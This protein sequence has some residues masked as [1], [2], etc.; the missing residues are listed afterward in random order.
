MSERQ[1]PILET[2]ERAAGQPEPRPFELEELSPGQEQARPREEEE[3]GG[4]RLLVY[5]GRQEDPRDR[6]RRQAKALMAKAEEE[7]AALVEEAKGQAEGIRRQAYEEGY[8]KGHE[9][10]LNAAK[11]LVEA[12]ADNLARALTALDRVRADIL[13]GLEGEIVGLVQAVCDRVFAT[14][15][16]V[17]AGVIKQ[18]V[19]E[20]VGR[21]LEFE[22]VTVR[23]SQKDMATIEEFRPE[24]LKAFTELG[25]LNLLADAELAPGDCVVDTP[26]A[27][28][29]ATLDTRRRRVFQALEEA[30]KGNEPLDLSPVLEEGGDEGGDEGGEGDAG[31]EGA[32]GDAAPE[33]AGTGGEPGAAE[34]EDW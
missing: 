24:L 13:A 28:V 3:E 11:A 18:V 16:A 20:A 19:K 23:L 7:S 6:A 34:I 22:K 5:G 25:R 29:D 8:Q 21:L 4:F 14:P 9:E 15:G 1:G 10:G 26:T 2:E 33:G 30:L 17:P 32:E 31:A 27:R 12:A